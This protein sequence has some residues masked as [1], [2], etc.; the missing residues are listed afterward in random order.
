MDILVNNAG[1]NPHYGSLLDV[2]EK[3]WDKLWDTNVKVRR[4]LGIRC[5]SAKSWLLLL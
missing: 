3:V 4:S 2:P 5:E 1:I